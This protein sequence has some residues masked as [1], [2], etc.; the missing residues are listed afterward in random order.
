MRKEKLRDSLLLGLWRGRSGRGGGEARRRRPPVIHKEVV[1]LVR[2]CE[3]L[4]HVMSWLGRE[5]GRDR[6]FLCGIEVSGRG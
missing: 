5:Q 3:F 6:R 4:F 2:K 1:D